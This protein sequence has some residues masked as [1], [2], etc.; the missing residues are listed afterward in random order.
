M[1]REP[2]ENVSRQSRVNEGKILGGMREVWKP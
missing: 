1:R 2:S